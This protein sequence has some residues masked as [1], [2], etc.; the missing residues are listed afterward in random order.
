MSFSKFLQVLSVLLLTLLLQGFISKAKERVQRST[1]PSIFQLYRDLWKLFHKRSVVP[2]SA[3]WVYFAAPVVAFTAMLI[4]AVIKRG[5]PVGPR[6][7]SCNGERFVR[8][9]RLRPVAL[10]PRQLPSRRRLK[11]R[12]VLSGTG[13]NCKALTARL[14]SGI[15]KL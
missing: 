7:R 1:G 15:L 8:I 6:S 2:E 5:K 10:G 4:V 12:R 3:A 14:R 11:S 9:P 13:Q